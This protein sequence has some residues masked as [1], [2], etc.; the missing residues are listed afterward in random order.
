MNDDKTLNAAIRHTPVWPLRLTRAGMVAERITRA[1]WPVW[2]LCFTTIAALAFGFQDWAPVELFWL[3]CLAVP[4]G[5]AGALWRGFRRFCWPS[6]GE[7]IQRL[8]RTLPGRPLAALA[9]HQALGDQDEGSKAVWQAH[10][11]RMLAR[12]A[13]ARRVAPDLRLSD[14][15]PYALRYAA[16]TAVLM[17]TLFGSLWRIADLAHPGAGGVRATE[18]RASW[19]GW[20][21]PPAHTGRP[22]LY[23]GS[24]T[25]GQITLPQGSRVVIRLYGPAEALTLSE[26][27]SDPAPARKPAANQT[28]ASDQ[29]SSDFIVGHSG[30]LAITGE[31][32]RT[33]QV[34]VQPDLAPA[35]TLAGP[36]ARLAK[37]VMSQPFTAHDD[38]A[39]TKGEARFD[40]D[41]SALDRRF[42]LAAEPDAQPAL[43]FDLPLP[44]SGHRSDF[45]Q[46]LAE[47]ASQHVWANLPVKMT[48]TVTDAI[49]QTGSTQT[50]TVV[51]PGRRFFDPLAEAI[52]E[53]RR[54]LLWSRANA[55]R[56]LQILRAVTNRPE[57]FIKNQSAYLMLRVAIRQLDAGLAQGLLAPA[58]RDDLAAALWQV[59]LLIEDGGLDDALDKMKRAQERLS[60]AMRNGASPDEIQRL[61]DDLRAATDDYLAMLAEKGQQDP[62][63]RFTK[64]QPTQKITQ[65]QLNQMMDQIQKLMEQGRMAEAQQLL[66]QLNQLLQNLKVTQ[67]E[68]GSGKAGKG[69]GAMDDLRRTLRD[70]QSLSDDAFRQGQQ[71]GPRGAGSQQQGD[72]GT[73]PG[74]QNP[75]GEQG[76]G[77]Q[78]SDGDKGQSL[79]DRQKALRHQLDSQLGALP[80][81]QGQDAD[82]A[83]RA[84]KDAGQA[85]DQAERALRDGNIPDAIDHQAGAIQNLHD[86]LRSM[87]DALARS[88]GQSPDSGQ[89]GQMQSGQGDGDNTDPLGRNGPST[90]PLIR[91]GG[92]FS[93]GE[94]VY[95][96]AR[97]LLDD[98]RRRAAD[99]S[100]PALELDYLK[101]LL[102]RF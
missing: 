67:G 18:A 82:R 49:G 100:R 87:N 25:G 81:A 92:A 5:L 68:G 51:L 73:Q 70:Q 84:L 63:D 66:D 45:V 90:D 60:E 58:P 42:G 43:T 56:S 74:D 86:G 27:L 80:D 24:L 20:A 69:G 78:G 101:R 32:G 79:A 72:E 11:A 7:A 14:R 50:R 89:D 59:A 97:E 21:E 38:Y 64:N 35:V 36:M 65:D 57:G 96:H 9:D 55:P 19:E 2:T 77:S 91:N 17:A 33:W 10:L 44:V 23:L 6:R 13:Q 22:S 31:G 26:T 37:G 76:D 48:L 34:T 83:R 61:M 94:D 95:R 12:A 53:L 75:P 39:V 29:R 71:Q 3:A 98:L 88:Q 28:V 16:L 46:T 93:Q 102:G 1:F 40:L 15:D 30:T 47:D 85:M 54:D 41:L 52:I 8:D 62:A 4:A 99:P